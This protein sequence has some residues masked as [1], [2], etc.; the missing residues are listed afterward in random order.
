[1]EHKKE[2]NKED[3]NKEKEYKDEGII[4]KKKII[5]NKKSE[6]EEEKIGL[7]SEKTLLNNFKSSLMGLCCSHNECIFLQNSIK[8]NQLKFQNYFDD[9]S[10]EITPK[11]IRNK[12]IKIDSEYKKLKFVSG[13]ILRLLLKKNLNKIIIEKEV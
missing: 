10:I 4:N 12:E 11:E 13:P 5:E 8:Q 7:N 1:M 6:N 2:Q 3:D 9:S